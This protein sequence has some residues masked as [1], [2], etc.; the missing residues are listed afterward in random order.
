MVTERFEVVPALADGGRG[1]SRSTWGNLS[2]A[3]LAPEPALVNR[4]WTVRTAQQ[5][6]RPSRTSRPSDQSVRYQVVQ[7]PARNWRS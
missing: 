3:R 4:L 6:A 5:P 2:V 7:I 1:G